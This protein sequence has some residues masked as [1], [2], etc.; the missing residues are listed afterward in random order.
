MRVLDEA[1]IARYHAVLAKLHEAA[2]LI[3]RLNLRHPEI[4]GTA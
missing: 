1:G 2:P 3:A 4:W